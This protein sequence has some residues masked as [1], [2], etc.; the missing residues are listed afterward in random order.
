MTHIKENSFT[1]FPSFPSNRILLSNQKILDAQ[2]FP[3]APKLIIEE[4]FM[5]IWALQSWHV[6][7]LRLKD[8]ELRLWNY[9][10]LN[11]EID[12]IFH[13]PNKENFSFLL[14]RIYV[15]KENLFLFMTSVLFYKK[16][17]FDTSSENSKY[18]VFSF[19]LLCAPFVLAIQKV[20]WRICVNLRSTTWHILDTILHRKP[21]CQMFDKLRIYYHLKFFSL[22]FL[23]FFLSLFFWPKSLFVLQVSTFK[24]IIR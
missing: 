15:T 12:N 18:R 14:P 7:L 20:P 10:F 16:G 19:L 13:C 9:L 2:L 21:A 5:P 3:F 24:D 22:Y 6:S 17:S 8:L 11:K 1:S 23:R 4:I